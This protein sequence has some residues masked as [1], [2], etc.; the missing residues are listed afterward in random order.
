M[1]SSEAIAAASP[2][3]RQV[4]AIAPKF[5]LPVTPS[6]WVSDSINKS[7]KSLLKIVDCVTRLKIHAR[8]FN[9]N[10][11]RIFFIDRLVA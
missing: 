2:K 1:A 6:R 7:K 8:Q 3:N 9:H 4:S 10:S 11:R 5:C